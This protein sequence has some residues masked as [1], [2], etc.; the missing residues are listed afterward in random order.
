MTI[1]L[2]KKAKYF[3]SWLVTGPKNM[4]AALNT[5]PSSS[6]YQTLH[7]TMTT[8]TTTTTRV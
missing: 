8:T 6:Y 5:G 7:T 4:L 2:N 3:I 1:N